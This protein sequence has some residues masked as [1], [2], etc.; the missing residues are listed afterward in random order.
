M[1]MLRHNLQAIEAN[2]HL[3]RSIAVIDAKKPSSLN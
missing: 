2:N 1:Q 3:H